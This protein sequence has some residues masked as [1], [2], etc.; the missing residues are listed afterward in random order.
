METLF[1]DQPPEAFDN[2]KGQVKKLRSVV[3]KSDK[4]IP[5]IELIG[6]LKAKLEICRNPEF[7]EQNLL[8]FVDDDDD[9]MAVETISAEDLL[10][11]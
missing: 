1:E 3:K 8:V 9:G 2:F 6:Q 11:F 7:T 5:S 4:D 10:D